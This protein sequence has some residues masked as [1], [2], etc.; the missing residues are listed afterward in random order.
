M[1][2]KCG[3]FQEIAEKIRLENKHIVM[4]GA[5]AVGTVTAPEILMDYSLGNYVDCYIDN[6]MRLWG[7]PVETC[8]G[9]RFVRSPE[10]LEQCS[11]DN[12]VIF[13]NIS[14]YDSVIKQLEAMKCTEKMICYFVPM[15][16]IHNFHQS[17]GQGV[18]KQFSK[19]VI[20]KTIH[21]IWL[22][23]NEMSENLQKC[24]DSWR[25]Y[26]PDYEIKCWNESNYDIEKNLYM[27][28]SYENRAFSF[29]TDY[30]RLDIL[31]NYGGIYLDTDV[32]LKKSLDSMLFQ[33]AFCGVEKW[34]ILNSGGGIG[35]IKGN[36]MIKQ[37]LDFR[38]TISFINPD[39]TQNR[40]TCGYY[41][42][43]VALR[44]GYKLNGQ[45]Q[46]IQG[47]TIYSSDYFHP[48]DYMT[49]KCEMTDD[50]FSVHHFNGGWL[51][52]EQQHANREAA[53][54][55]DELFRKAMAYDE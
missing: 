7:S 39:G 23:S 12:T 33:E 50:T 43:V 40:N 27:K 46:R 13:L 37:L 6:N 24:I 47:M 45:N 16:C 19:P 4:F 26:C 5:G 25:K 9:K 20:P 48:Y 35:A 52:E 51:T 34:Q 30:A 38:N 53:L 15:M 21:Y 1:I 36:K 17:G 31:Y 32:E 3:N 22:G 10:Y 55:Y 29:V 11:A 8:I 28:Q 2:I 41:E 42:T 54:K 49:G 44:N 18:V 14:R